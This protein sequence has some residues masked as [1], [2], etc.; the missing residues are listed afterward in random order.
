MKKGAKYE[1]IFKYEEM[2]LAIEI[3]KK[4]KVT[5]TILSKPDCDISFLLY[6][7]ASNIVVVCTRINLMTKNIIIQFSML[8]D[9]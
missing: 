9:K 8:I 2:K 1:L 3:L 5:S 7:N 6:M 4:V